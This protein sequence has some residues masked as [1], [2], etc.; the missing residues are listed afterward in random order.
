ML[1][2]SVMEAAVSD[3]VGVS[4]GRLP[5]FFCFFRLADRS[6][7][8]TR[9]WM[10]QKKKIE[11]HQLRQLACLPNLFGVFNVYI[12]VYNNILWSDFDGEW[13]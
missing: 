9:L 5:S 13:G 12:G 8:M 2:R 1:S 11:Y 7:P 6:E 10:S 3:T 4:T